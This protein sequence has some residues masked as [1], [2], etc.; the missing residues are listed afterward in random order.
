M[1]KNYLRMKP[2]NFDEILH[3]VQSFK[4]SKDTTHLREPIAPEIKLVP[5]V[6][7]AIYEE[8]KGRY[9]KV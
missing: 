5:E 1:Y 3:F 2:E 7:D 4:V 8:L 6:C 9:L